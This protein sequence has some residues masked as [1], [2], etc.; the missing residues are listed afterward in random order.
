MKQQEHYRCDVPAAAE[1][2]EP[3]GVCSEKS[4]AAP[5]AGTDS[6][7]CP[8]SATTGLK[9]DLITLKALLTGEGLRRLDGEN[10]R[11]CPAADCDVVYFDNAA[12]SVYRRRD[13]TV[14][15]GQKERGDSAPI[16]YCFGYTTGDV[17]RDFATLGTTRIPAMITAQVKAGHCACEVKNPQGSCC[18]GNVSKAVRRVQAELADALPGS[19]SEGGAER[20]NP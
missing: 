2:G 6:G 19:R 7:L 10:Y 13:L 1:P 14:R 18:L 4:P 11:F 3:S 16:C 9:V 17:R 20:A 15:I 5:A 12:N 8:V